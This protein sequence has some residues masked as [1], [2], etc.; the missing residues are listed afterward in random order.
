MMA[1]GYLD[2]NSL[3]EKHNYI[4]KGGAWYTINIPSIGIE[5]KKTNGLSKQPKRS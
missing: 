1:V 2:R 3:L 4:V 5:N